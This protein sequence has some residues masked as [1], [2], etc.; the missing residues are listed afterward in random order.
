M[1][2]VCVERSQYAQN[3][4]KISFDTGKR[5]VISHIG[6]GGDRGKNL[7]LQVNGSILSWTDSGDYPNEVDRDTGEMHRFLYGAVIATF[8]CRLAHRLGLRL[9]GS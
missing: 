6:W 2:I 9:G 3:T 5:L 4:E 7:P 1:T 8:D